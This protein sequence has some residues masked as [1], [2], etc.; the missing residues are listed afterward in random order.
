MP[1]PR[2]EDYHRTIIGYHGTRESV[3]LEIVQNKRRF[4]YSRNKD[5]WLGHGVYFWEHAPQ[6]AW[7]WAE[8]RRRRQKWTENVAVLGAMIR[9]GS[10]F[11]LLDPT[12][13]GT[14]IE[15]YEDFK[16]TIAAAEKRLPKNARHHRYLDCAVFE[17]AYAAFKLQGIR[18]D[19]C[20]AVYAP[21]DE[22][23]RVW[24]G[25]WISRGAH[26]QICVRNPACL[27]GAWLAKPQEGEGED[28]G[29]YGE[30]TPPAGSA[31]G[32]RE[33]PPGGGADQGT[34]AVG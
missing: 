1:A 24:P 13:V 27:L 21:T 28:D 18:V 4:K 19:S 33:A 7:W 8:R 12:N 9:L 14:L 17:Y 11:D 31:N 20:R 2:F 5:D 34:S 23:L 30:E 10:C 29:Q 15:A 26:I 6:Q 25:S 3:A 16:E 32:G 22:K